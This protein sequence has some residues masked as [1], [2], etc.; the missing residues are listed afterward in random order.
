[1]TAPLSVTQKLVLYKSALLDIE[2]ILKDQKLNF[3]QKQKEI[4][5]LIDDELNFPS[6]EDKEALLAMRDRIL[7]HSR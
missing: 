3:K 1:M 6:E 5:S 7:K 2:A 4:L